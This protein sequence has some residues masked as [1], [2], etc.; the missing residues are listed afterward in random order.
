MTLDANPASGAP[1]PPP[2]APPGF[3]SRTYFENRCGGCAEYLATGG[4]ELDAIRAL[5]LRLL[6]PAHGEWV[7]DLGAGRGE[8]CAAMAQ[9]GARVVGVDFSRDALAMARETSLRLGAPFGLVC[10]RAEALPLRSGSL[11]AALA[12]DIV[13]HLPDPDLRAAVREVRRALKP[14]GRFVVHTAPTSAFL[15]FGQHVNRWLQR[16]TGNVV[17]PLLTYQ[18]EL[19]EAGH[20]NIHSRATL[21]AALAP[22]FPEP[23]VFYAFSDRSRPGR[24]LAAALG[25]AA[26]LGFNLWAVARKGE[27]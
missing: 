5:A 4:R 1:P 8:L 17:A 22:D 20:S 27:T 23:A 15:A 9:A 6:A 12:T 16:L 25:L 7:L 18:S 11:D 2:Q 24:R 14:R 13:E 21:Q 10:A 3:Y 19:A 26:V